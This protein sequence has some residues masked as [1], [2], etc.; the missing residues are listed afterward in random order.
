MQNLDTVFKAISPNKFYSNMFQELFFQELTAFLQTS[1]QCQVLLAH[2][3]SLGEHLK[4]I[5]S[6]DNSHFMLLGKAITLLGGK[7]EL[8][9]LKGQHFSGKNIAYATNAFDII[10]E[11]IILKENLIIS[12]KTAI[13]KIGTQ[14]LKKLLQQILS[15][16]EY[17]LEI[18]KN[19]IKNFKTQS[20]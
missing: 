13:K 1:F 15:Q 8:K 17:H 9:N 11:D 16:E 2:G 5:S 6:H 19:V 20:K 14:N 12:Y 10:L 18:L 3:I 4:Q 7:P